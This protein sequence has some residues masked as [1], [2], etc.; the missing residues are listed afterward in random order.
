MKRLFLFLAILMIGGVAFAVSPDYRICD[1]AGDCLNINADGTVPISGAEGDVTDVGDCASGACFKGA[2]VGGNILTFEGVTADAFE[3]IVSSDDVTADRYIYLPNDEIASGDV[4]VGASAGRPAYV[5]VADDQIIVGDGTGAPAAVSI[6]DSDGATQKL[7]YDTATNAFSAGTDDD[8][9]EAGDYAA[10]SI[11]GDDINSN[12]AGRSLTL[13]AAAPDTLDSDAE[14]YTDSKCV[15]VENPVATD[16]LVSIWISDGFASTITRI[17][18]ESDQTWTA[19]LQVDDGTPADVASVD[20]VCVSGTSSD[21]VLAGDSGLADGDRLDL[22]T[23]SVSGVP[24]RGSIC[25][26]YTKND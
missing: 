7:Q 16:D 25:W 5:G 9:P 10:A 22:K 11:D 14:L 12:L 20:L 26:K 15:Y 17:Y 6:T 13:T 21:T 3:T 23:T 19:N 24:T 1:E 8:A 4:I 2:A 18:C